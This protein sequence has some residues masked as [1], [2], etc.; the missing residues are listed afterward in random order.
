MAAFPMALRHREV[1][2]EEDGREI[3]PRDFSQVELQEH[4][5]RDMQG[6]PDIQLL[7]R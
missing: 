4:L 3:S 6:A 5:V 7:V 2:E 1:Q